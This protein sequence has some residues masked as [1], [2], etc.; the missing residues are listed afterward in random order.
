M[1]Q[2][3]CTVFKIYCTQCVWTSKNINS[4]VNFFFYGTTSI[5]SR[6]IGSTDTFPRNATSDVLFTCMLDIWGGGGILSFSFFLGDLSC[7]VW[8]CFIS[9]LICRNITNLPKFIPFVIFFPFSRTKYKL[10]I[11]MKIS[12]KS[13]D[14]YSWIYQ[15]EIISCI[16]VVTLKSLKRYKI[17]RLLFG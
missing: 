3:T 16:I 7:L 8:F 12:G 5:R 14:W 11:F 10:W 17:Q 9:R 6:A 1:W 4:L 15:F 2:F 13:I